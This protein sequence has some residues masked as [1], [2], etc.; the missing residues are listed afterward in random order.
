V[1]YR[2]NRKRSGPYIRDRQADPIYR[3]GALCNDVSAQLI[4]DLDLHDN[5][6]LIRSDREHRSD[7]VNVSLHEVTAKASANLQRT[8]QIHRIARF[9]AAEIRSRERLGHRV[10]RER[11]SIV[12]IE[13]NA[14]HGKAA[15]IHGNTIAQFG[16]IAHC[17]CRHYQFCASAV[18]G[19]LDNPPRFFHKPRKHFVTPH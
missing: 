1:W 17:S 13:V 10:E 15:A 18:Y 7:V 8:L 12:E 4:R 16:A 14:Y 5:G 19:T 11:A 6:V 9:Q 3:N 2:P